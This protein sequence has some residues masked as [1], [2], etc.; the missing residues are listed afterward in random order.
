MPLYEYRCE[1]CLVIYQRR[2]GMTDAPLT[3][4]PACGGPVTRLLSVAHLNLRNWSSPTAAKY[5][6]MTASEEE[7]L[8]TAL[9]KSYRTIR[10]PDAVKHDPWER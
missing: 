5:A 8:E 1:P 4:C 7:A 10:L 3:V 9:Q 2:Q 6:G